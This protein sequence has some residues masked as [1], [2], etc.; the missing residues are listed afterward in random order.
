L[1]LAEKFAES[2][3]A[4]NGAWWKSGEMKT[5]ELV[6]PINVSV[7]FLEGFVKDMML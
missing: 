6:I 4:V 5:I 2:F 1:G 7:S 3:V